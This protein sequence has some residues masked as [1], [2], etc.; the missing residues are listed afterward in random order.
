DSIDDFNKHIGEH[1][2]QR[3][4]L[5]GQRQQ[6]RDEA[7]RL[8]INDVLVRNGKRLEALLEQQDWLQ[9]VQRM[10]TEVADEVKHLE[11]RLMSENERL[12]H[13]WTGAGKIPPRITSDTVDQLTPQ[14]RA[15]EATE[16]MVATAKHELEVHRTGHEE[17]RTQIE[18]A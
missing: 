18:S 16:Q 6:L 10:S 9:S 5:K 4:I 3:D 14:A 2:R 15:V 12:S 8:G 13:E 11:A 17:F 7:Q 1:E